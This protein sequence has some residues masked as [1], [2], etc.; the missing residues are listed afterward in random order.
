MINSL[1]KNIDHNNLTNSN[2]KVCD[3]CGCTCP[4]ECKD[5]KE[6]STCGGD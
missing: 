3:G 6:C 4:C 1:L 2:E 5:C